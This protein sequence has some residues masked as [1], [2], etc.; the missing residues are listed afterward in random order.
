MFVLFTLLAMLA[1]SVH[2]GGSTA[3]QAAAPAATMAPDD[4][5]SGGPVG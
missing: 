4:G 2:A 5:N 1:G 3:P